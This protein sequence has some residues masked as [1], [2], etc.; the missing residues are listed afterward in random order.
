MKNLRRLRYW[1]AKKRKEIISGKITD[2]FNWQFYN[3]RYRDELEDISKI[4]TL[5]LQS[6]DYVFKNDSLIKARNSILPLHPNHRLLYET[7][8][9]L[10]PHS[11]LELGCGGGDHLHNINVL[12]PETKLYGYEY[13][14]K[15]LLL[16]KERHPDF[17]GDIKQFDCTLPFPTDIP[18][19]DI[20]YTQAV[21]MHIQTGNGH[22]VAL[23]NLFRASSRQV[24][25]MENW[26]RHAFMED[27]SKLFSLRIIPWSEIY[28]HYR[29][30]EELK[31]PHLMVVSSMPLKEYPVLTDYG[32]LFDN[33]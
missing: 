11:L 9:Q 14:D 16:F 2:D 27:I 6:D 7:I 25:L 22:L 12:S 28:F 18:K 8:I 32:V 30:S 13:S 5:I 15:Q 24:I 29:E 3:M 19:V 23:S 1:I 33:V 26:T 4:H 31:K 21:L 17:S 10:G 20:A